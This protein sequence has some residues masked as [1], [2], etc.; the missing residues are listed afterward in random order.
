MLHQLWYSQPAVLYA[1]FLVVAGVLYCCTACVRRE[2]IRGSASQPAVLYARFL[3]EA[4][5]LYCCTACV[6]RERTRGS[7]IFQKK[8]TESFF[9]VFSSV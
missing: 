6:R 2:R 9:F 3:V 4:G 1:R 8:M 7:D 5:V